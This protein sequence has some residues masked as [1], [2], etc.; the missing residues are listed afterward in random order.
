MP[1]SPI[2]ASLFSLIVLSSRFVTKLPEDFIVQKFTVFFTGE[3][4]SQFSLGS[5]IFLRQ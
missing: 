3:T 4:P 5:F 2:H 1:A